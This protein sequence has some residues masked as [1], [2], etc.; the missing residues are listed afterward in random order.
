MSKTIFSIDVETSTTN[1][2]TG[3]L[4][5]VGVVAIDFDT[6]E[7][8]KSDYWELTY[9]ESAKLDSS[10]TYEWWE[11]Q[12]EQ[13][14]EAAWGHRECRLAPN[15]VAELLSEFIIGHSEDWNDRIFAANPSTFDYGWINQLLSGAS[16]EDTFHY[17]TICIRSLAFG[18]YGGDWGGG[19]GESGEWYLP[20][21]P[22]HA[23]FDALAQGQ[24]LIKL[25]EK[26]RENTK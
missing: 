15:T 20:E 9:P 21:V 8:G 13:A 24:D 10:D 12:N 4:L 26:V 11:K 2:Y 23:Y 19:R 3:N 18:L 7:I 25:L 16:V 6:L 22:H 1:P 14:F 5:S 17:R